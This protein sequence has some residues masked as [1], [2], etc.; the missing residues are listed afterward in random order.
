MKA[1][2]AQAQ[3]D[4]PCCSVVR[5]K[6]F[7]LEFIASD[8]GACRNRHHGRTHTVRIAVCRVV[9]HVGAQSD[10]AV[11]S[12]YTFSILNSKWPYTESPLTVVIPVNEKTLTGADAK[13]EVSRLNNP[14]VEEYLIKSA[15]ARAVRYF[16]TAVISIP[17]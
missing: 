14:R 10:G 13:V 6:G 11:S 3:P 8:Q 5:P 1:A 17:L 7:D 16:S 4:L 12:E 15:D 2:T 9:S